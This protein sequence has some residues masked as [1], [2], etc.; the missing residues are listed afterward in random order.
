MEIVPIIYNDRTSTEFTVGY[1]LLELNDL[2]D[3]VV[4]KLSLSS[5]QLFSLFSRLVE[6]ARVHLTA[7]ANTHTH[8]VYSSN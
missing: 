4:N 3:S 5:H 1:L 7:Y 6:E 2:H 8:K